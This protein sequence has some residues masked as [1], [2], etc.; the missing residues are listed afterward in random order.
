MEHSIYNIVLTCIDINSA[1]SLIR[2]IYNTQLTSYPYII[3]KK[4]N[5]QNEGNKQNQDSNMI[6]LYF[7]TFDFERVKMLILYKY[8]L[9]NHYQCEL[10]GSVY[11]IGTICSSCG[12]YLPNVGCD[13]CHT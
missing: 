4:G 7:Q 8:N 13:R 6:E 1:K 11:A 5:K 9:L 3:K 2:E 10:A 12:C